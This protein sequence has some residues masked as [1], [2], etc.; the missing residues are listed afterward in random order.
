MHIG[1]VGGVYFAFKE[2]DGGAA[3]EGWVLPAV[4]K[5]LFR[6]IVFGKLAGGLR[7]VFGVEAIAD[8][9]V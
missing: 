2:D 5:G 8:F 9:G 4:E 3:F 1:V 7:L 6:G